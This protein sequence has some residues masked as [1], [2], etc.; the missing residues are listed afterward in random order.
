MKKLFWTIYSF[1]KLEKR[2]H[3]KSTFFHPWIKKNIFIKNLLDS[4]HRYFR[5]F[6]DCQFMVLIF[7]N[8]VFL[9]FV[10]ASNNLHFVLNCI[11]ASLWDISQALPKNVFCYK[12]D[13]IYLEQKLLGNWPVGKMS[14]LTYWWC[15][16]DITSDLSSLM[17]QDN[18][19]WFIFNNIDIICSL[20][21]WM[22]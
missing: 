22:I 16:G 9:F 5:S 10:R 13:Y 1:I 6:K 2:R 14:I 19:S 12:T 3:H 18:I 8:F 15:H 7:L 17:C 21:S 4:L 20:D 11:I